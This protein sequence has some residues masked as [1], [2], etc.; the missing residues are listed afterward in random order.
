M[1]LHNKMRSNEQASARGVVGVMI[2]V[3]MLWFDA[4]IEIVVCNLGAPHGFSTL[5]QVFHAQLMSAWF[6][7]S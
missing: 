1:G 6:V 7:H 5:A 4:H 2:A 3:R